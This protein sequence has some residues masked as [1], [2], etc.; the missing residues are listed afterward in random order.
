MLKVAVGGSCGIWGND[1]RP[2]GFKGWPQTPRK[3]WELEPK[4]LGFKGLH[5]PKLTI[6]L[7]RSI[8]PGGPCGRLHLVPALL[9]CW[10]NA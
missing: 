2:S 10:P 9:Q 8:Q 6:Y 4:L 3:G 7:S 5:L 1:I